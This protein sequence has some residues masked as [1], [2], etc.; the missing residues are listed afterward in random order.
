[1]SFAWHCFPTRGTSG[2]FIHVVFRRRFVKFS[3]GYKPPVSIEQTFEA[4]AD[5]IAAGRRAALCAIVATRGSTPQPA[6]AMVCVNDAV[7]MTGTLGGGCVEA[8]VRRR[9]YE[10]LVRG[11]SEL[12]TFQLDHDFGYDDG[13]ICG[14][15]MDVAISVFEGASGVELLQSAYG[16]IRAGREAIIP[17]RVQGDQGWIEYRVVLEESPE[18]VVVGAGHIGRSLARLAVPLGFRVSVIDDRREHAN[19]DRFPPPIRP[20]VGDIVETLRGW[21]VGPNTYIVI[22]TRGHKH[23]ERALGAVLGRSAKYVGMIGSRRKIMVTFDDLLHAGASAVELDRVHAP[24][25]LDIGAITPEEIAV[26]IA[27]ELIAVRRASRK[28]AVEGPFRVSEREPMTPAPY[29]TRIACIVPAAGMSRRMGR[30]KVLM[31]IRGSTM[32]GT[33]VRRLLE[34]GADEIVVVTRG[35]LAAQLDLPTD[36]RVRIAINDAVESEMMDSLRVG[37]AA[38]KSPKVQVRP[39]PAGNP[40][41]DDEGARDTRTGILVV[42]ADMPAIAVFTYRRC[43]DVYRFDSR[44]IV[45]AAHHGKRGHPVVLPSSLLAELDQQTRSL[46]ECME[47]NGDDVALV[48]TDDPG[49]LHDV[50]SPADYD[51]ALKCI[52]HRGD[53]A[54]KTPESGD[55]RAQGL[56]AASSPRQYRR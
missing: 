29:P 5:E 49:V 53:S 35:E 27:A 38:L 17:L 32:V 55:R 39:D 19:A 3:R 20:V 45:I 48:E 30:P 23:D 42:P 25:G 8:E 33:V 14:G 26:S 40:A 2:R 51:K 31:P 18:L 50:D 54:D 12:L 41:T 37:L 28:S 22:V 16:R 9:A 13:L 56:R 15:Q 34:A 10:L 24:V 43:M 21:A 11:R 52:A 44:R 4:L 6:G 7:S 47:A 36:R 1:M 46:K